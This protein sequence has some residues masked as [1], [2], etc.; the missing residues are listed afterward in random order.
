MGYDD[1]NIYK[2]R[3]PEVPEFIIERDDE[4]METPEVH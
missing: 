1:K 3:E 4:G 2:D